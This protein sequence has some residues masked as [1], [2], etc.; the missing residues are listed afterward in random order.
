MSDF[1]PFAGGSYRLGVIGEMSVRQPPSPWVWSVVTELT[2]P[3]EEMSSTS[4]PATPLGPLAGPAMPLGLNAESLMALAPAMPLADLDNMILLARSWM[5]QIRDMDIFLYDRVNRCIVALSQVILLREGAHFSIGSDE[6]EMR[7]RET[8]QEWGILKDAVGQLVTS[9]P[10]RPGPLAP[11]ALPG[12]FASPAAFA[13]KKATPK[14]PAQKKPAQKRGTP[15]TA[16]Q[17]TAKTKAD[18]AVAEAAEKKA[19]KAA[20]AEEAKKKA[21]KAVALKSVEKAVKEAEKL[22]DADKEFVKAR[23]ATAKWRYRLH[24]IS[25][26]VDFEKKLTKAQRSKAAKAVAEAEKAVADTEKEVTEA[27]QAKK[28]RKVIAET[29]E[30]TAV[31]AVAQAER[32]KTVEA[33]KRVRNMLASV[34]PE[35]TWGPASWPDGIDL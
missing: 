15:K 20:V 35:A 30:K 34:Y 18:K 29:W 23:Q 2:S 13:P 22:K 10:I 4:P 17:K 8:S 32:L 19:E 9:H 5:D 14:K 24:K 21:E 3:D 11:P 7:L 25:E 27:L 33:K 1:V 12:P 26:G 28:K 16:A 31:E 6:F